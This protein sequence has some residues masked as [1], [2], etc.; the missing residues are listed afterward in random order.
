MTVLFTAL[1]LAASLAWAITLGRQS[2]PRSLRVPLRSATARELGR[3]AAL[4]CREL[5][6]LHRA[7]WRRT[8]IDPVGPPPVPPRSRR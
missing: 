7:R 6:R 5:T 1:V 8:G 4:G 3:D 2:L